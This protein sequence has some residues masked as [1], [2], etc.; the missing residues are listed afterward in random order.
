MRLEITPDTVEV[1]LAWWEKFLGLLKD[2]RV[3]RADISDVRV[4]EN[5]VR[6]AMGTGIKA[7]L[8]LPF[9]LYIA[10]TLR[11]DE[12]FVVRR[13]VPGLS[14]A[15]ENHGALKRVLLSTPQA[16]EMAQ[17]LKRGD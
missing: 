10:R 1:H 7:G 15:V 9:L 3:P 17:R 13:G 6:E 8:R 11:L 4:V 12:A 5:P 16:E 2:I 14:F